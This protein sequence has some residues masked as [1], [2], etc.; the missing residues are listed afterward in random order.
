MSK[1]IYLLFLLITVDSFAQKSIKEYV[2]A[3]AV[4]IR[5]ID[6]NENDF[7][8]LD[9]FGKAIGDSRIVALGEQNHGDG[10]TFEAKGRLVRYLHEKKGFNVLVFESDY[11]A[12][13]YGFEKVT[14]TKDSINNFIQ[15]NIM[16]VWTWCDKAA[17]LF[18][19]YIPN[20]HA[21]TNPLKIAG[22]D[23]Q[24][25]GKYSVDN[26]VNTAAP[27]FAKLS[28]TEDEVITSKII[29]KNLYNTFLWTY[30]PPDS[31]AIINGN[32]ALKSFLKNKKLDLLT[33]DERLLIDNIK[34]NYDDIADVVQ[35]KSYIN[36][37]YTKRDRQMFQNLMWLLNEKYPND[38]IIIWAHSAHIA[39]AS[40][41][42]ED[43][44]QNGILLGNFLGNKKYN[45]FSYFALGFTSYYATP[46]WTSNNYKVNVEKP[47]RDG[48]ENWIPKNFNYAYV[49]FTLTNEILKNNEAFAM[50]GTNFPSHQHKNLVYQWTK[51][52]DG[53][54]FIKNIEGCSKIKF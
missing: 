27:I 6:I 26:L 45:Q 35:N 20:T 7:S 4:E 3:N 28:T 46:I 38:K 40:K 2:K 8:D 11:F 18:Y 9:I 37:N 25:H 13:T 52:F 21:T 30:N 51:V 41:T 43:L 5:S 39:K 12:L 15:K 19:N 10:T 29:L 1:N 24:F 32:E 44:G 50:K 33:V 17:P 47:Q 48:F 54:F 36:D 49:N 14:K 42:F 16:G 23:C 22:M 34:R 31:L 53:I